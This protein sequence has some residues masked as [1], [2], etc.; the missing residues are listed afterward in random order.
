M[1]VWKGLLVLALAVTL[2]GFF[3]CSKGGKYGEAKELLNKT[4]TAMED[5]AKAM[6]KATEAKAVAA[7]INK[8][9]DA[10]AAIKPRMQALDKKFP[11]LKDETKVPEELKPFIKKMEEMSSKMIS[12][13][14]KAYQFIQDPEVQKA[15]E[16]LNKVM[17]D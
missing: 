3:A 7:G 1:K 14:M 6:D 16:E 2:A 12:A 8:F 9:K 17:Q 4:V 10:M 5:F 11:E 15:Q 13:S